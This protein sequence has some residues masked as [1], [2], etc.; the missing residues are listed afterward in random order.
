MQKQTQKQTQVRKMHRMRGQT[1]RE[2]VEREP[3]RGDAV[4]SR[5]F[6]EHSQDGREL[7]KLPGSPCE[8]A[9]GMVS[10]RSERHEPELGTVLGTA[11][12]GPCNPVRHW[13][14]RLLPARPGGIRHW[15]VWKRGVR[16]P[17]TTGGGVSSGLAEASTTGSHRPASP[18]QWPAAAGGG[19][20]RG[21]SRPS[22]SPPC[23]GLCWQSSQLSRLERIHDEVW[24][25]RPLT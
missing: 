14:G 15:R 22:P 8:V 23:G 5:A 13:H 11:P 4:S 19:P 1:G 2:R 12:R 25:G 21:P 24:C 16:V 6:D 9:P 3:K 17:L 18:P 7:G 10:Q 20:Q